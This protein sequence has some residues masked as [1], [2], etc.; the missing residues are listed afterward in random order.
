MWKTT[1]ERPA[2]YFLLP[3]DGQERWKVDADTTYNLAF[4]IVEGPVATENGS[5]MERT[6]RVLE[7]KDIEILIEH[8]INGITIYRDGSQYMYVTRYWD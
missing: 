4:R 5:Y 1:E 8:R 6:E 3:Q 7:S 2:F